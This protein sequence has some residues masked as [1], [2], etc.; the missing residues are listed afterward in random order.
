VV[1]LSFI[2]GPDNPGG[3]PNS[4][5]LHDQAALPQHKAVSLRLTGTLLLVNF[6]AMPPFEAQPRFINHH[7]KGGAFPPCAAAQPRPRFYRNLI[8]VGA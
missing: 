3:S 5:S 7:R 2:S 8:P 4:I 1:K 6:A